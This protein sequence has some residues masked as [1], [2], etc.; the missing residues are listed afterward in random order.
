MRVARYL[1]VI[2]IAR[3]VH[4]AIA[5]VPSNFI[6]PVHERYAHECFYSNQDEVLYRFV[7]DLYF[8]DNE[9]YQKNK[10]RAVKLLGMQ[11]AS[12]DKDTPYRAAWCYL[13]GF[14]TEK[15]QRKHS[16]A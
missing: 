15:I 5:K 6:A 13:N 14:G 16:Y 2:L 1:I 7:S 10:E 8:G 11:E 9:K 3:I 12:D 4:P